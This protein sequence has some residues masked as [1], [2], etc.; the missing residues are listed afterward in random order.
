MYDEKKSK[1]QRELYKNIG[2][3]LLIKRRELHYTQEQ[4][5]E[6]LGVSTGFYGMIERGEKAP[7]IEKLILIYKELGTDITYLLTGDEKEKQ[8]TNYIEKC[9]KEKQYDFEQL[10]KYALN[11]VGKG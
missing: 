11:L 1:V 10:I 6:L 8:M 9:P 3:R 7:S 5:A 4:M 2:N